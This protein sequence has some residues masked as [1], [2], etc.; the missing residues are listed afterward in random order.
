MDSPENKQ[1]A[2]ANALDTPPEQGDM[3]GP[4]SEGENKSAASAPSAK[5]PKKVSPIKKF[6]KKVNLY[7][8][9]FIFLAVIG[10]AVTIVSYLNSKKE[11]PTPAIANQPLN[12][13]A[14]DQ[15]AKTDTSVGGSGQTLTVQG[16]AIFTGQILAKSDVGVAGNILANNIKSN[17]DVTTP[18]LTVGTKATLNDAQANTLQV[19]STTTMQGTVT[20]QKDLNVGGS[21]SFSGP[22]IAG[23]LTVTRLIMSG[24]ASLNVPNHI[25]FTGASPGRS[26][27][28]GVLGAGGTASVNGSDVSG[29]LNINTGNSPTAGCFA[30]ITFNQ[31]FT[32]TPRVIVSP[33][34]AGAGQTQYYVERST[35]GFSICTNNAPP[36]NQVFGY[37]Y[38]IAGT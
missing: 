34:G 6:F 28:S 26:I 5:P 36:P 24:N 4:A 12:Q 19:A 33:F 25:A 20:M 38:F 21:T 7:L 16:N 27:N 11:A 13:E 37:D 17:T 9:I 32:A 35:S 15:L 3:T 22:V 8:L 14:L 30:N 31:K 18:Q 10:G 1:S 29:T 23:Q 2:P